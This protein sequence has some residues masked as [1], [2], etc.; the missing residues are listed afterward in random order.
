MSTL[1]VLE[2]VIAAPSA[3]L[4]RPSA[5]RRIGLAGVA[6]ALGLALL[7]TVMRSNADF[8]ETYVADQLG[9]QRITFKPADA[10]TAEE[11]GQPCLVRYAGSRLTTGS[12][13]ECYATSFIGQHLP[14]IADGKTFSE[15]RS[16][17]TT[18]RADLAS[19]QAAGDPAA[20][21]LQRQLGEITAKRQSLFEGETMKGLLLTT[22]GFSTL[23]A[24]AGQA[25]TAAYAGAGALVLLSAVLLVRSRRPVR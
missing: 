6:L 24:K 16:V 11:R 13:A 10:L 2:P 3:T 4:R 23:G 9:Q 17:Q 8:A 20:A 5:G 1:N 15:L 19:A 7:G 14:K 25:A 22:Y 21:D 18:L 12:Q